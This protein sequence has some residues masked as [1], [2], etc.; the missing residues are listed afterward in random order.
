M[1]IADERRLGHVRRLAVDSRRLALALLTAS[2]L[3]L[4]SAGEARAG[5]V[6]TFPASAD[7]WVSSGQPD[8]N[9][10]GS[11]R[12]SVQSG[13]D[14]RYAYLR[15]NV[16]IPSNRVIVKAWLL[17]FA[18]SEG[19]A[20]GV[21]LRRVPDNSWSELEANWRTRP[22]IDSGIV[23]TRAGWP[24]DSWVMWNATS[25]VQ[26]SGEVSFALT[27]PSPDW[28][29]FRSSESQSYT[30]P[31]LL[32]WTKRLPPPDDAPP[33]GPT[34]P[35]GPDIPPGPTGPTGP[36]GATGSSGPSG[37][38]GGSSGPGG[39][40]PPPDPVT[41]PVI[42]AAGDIS[43]ASLCAQVATSAL[44]TGL[45]RPDAVLGLGDYQYDFG[46]LDAFSRYYEPTWGVFKSKTYPINGGSHDFYGTGDYITYFNSGAPVTLQPEA[47]YS[48]DLGSWHIVALNASCFDRSSCDEDAWTEWLRNDLERNQSACTLAYFH[49]PYWTT[50]SSHSRTSSTK[51]WIQVL[52]E[53]GADVVL[54]AHNHVYERFAPQT[55]DDQF[56]PE[57]GIT[58]FTVGTGGRSH[59]GFSGDPAPNS[60]VRDDQTYG[61]LKMVLRANSYDYRFVPVDGATFVDAGSAACH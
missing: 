49:Q 51:P 6:Y 50:R 42:A 45:I 3:V 54:Q 1:W 21:Q 47:S 28:H 22:P 36:T 46:T 61:V 17:A 29:G 41:E 19:A 7:T 57:R 9:F 5:L 60:V 15:F 11:T 53:H 55:P 8:T 58:A 4:L 13:A 26:G 25:L 24:A 12:F 33:P 34:G 35:T 56:D 48:F 32:V 43:C 14:T 20:E 59:Y 38:T 18:R 27:S 16:A 37:P 23:S 52:Y 40:L 30:P 31:R 10:G 2:C 39:P 44:I